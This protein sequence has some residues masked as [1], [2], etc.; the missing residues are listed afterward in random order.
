MPLPSGQTPPRHIL[1][2]VGCS[3]RLPSWVTSWMTHR[4]VPNKPLKSWS[5]RCVQWN[6]YLIYATTDHAA[7]ASPDTVQ[8]TSGGVFANPVKVARARRNAVL[9]AQLPT[10]RPTPNGQDPALHGLLGAMREVRDGVLDDLADRRIDRGERKAARSIEQKWNDKTVDRICKMCGANQTEDL[11]PLYHELAAH[12]KTDGTVRSVL[13]DAV[14]F[15]ANALGIQHIP[16]V[17]VQHAT[18]LAG[19]VFF[20]AG[21]QSL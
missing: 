11:P 1:P 16:T 9:Y 14:E 5:P 21:N 17:T 18:E 10:L 15:T 8:L 6:D 2:E 19:W 12:K 20:G 3:Y 13:Q 7:G 4:E